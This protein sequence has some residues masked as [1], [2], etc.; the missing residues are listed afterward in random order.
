MNGWSWMRN[1]FVGFITTHARWSIA[2]IVAAI[3]LAATETQL[4]QSLEN[5]AFDV[6]TVATLP[7]KRTTPIIIVGIDD[8]S[9]SILGLGAFWPRRVHAQLIDALT[10]AGA[11]AIVFDV[12]FDRRSEVQDDAALAAAIHRAGNVV[13]GAG[14]PEV[15]ETTFSKQSHRREPL[16]MFLEAGATVGNLKIDV[17]GDSVVRRI[18]EA[19]DA[20]WRVALQVLKRHVPDLQADFLPAKNAYLRYLEPEQAPQYLPYIEALELAK[21]PG[22][23]NGA[24]MLVGAYS[25]RSEA[26]QTPLGDA[27]PYVEVHATAIEN[28]IRWQAIAPAHA[29]TRWLLTALLAAACVFSLARRGLRA[30]VAISLAWLVAIGALVVILWRFQQ[31][32]LPPAILLAIPLGVLLG[33]VVIVARPEKF[34]LGGEPREMTFLFTDLEGFTTLTEKRML[35]Q[36]EQL[37]NEYFELMAQAVSHHEG[38]LDKFIGDAVMAFWGAPVAHE[39]HPQRAVAC[40]CDMLDALDA[41]NV[42]LAE[43]G[44]PPLK[45]RIGI[46]TGVAV[47]GNLGC[48]SRFSYTAL[49]DAVNVASRLESAN[50]DYGT[51]ILM[52]E[53]TALGLPPGMPTR[54]IAETHQVKGRKEPLKLFTIDH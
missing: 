47:V 7:G 17:D 36:T 4:G 26:L 6:L 48:P 5:R 37:L 31:M 1:Y 51:S 52:S 2:L 20:L 15:E 9:R 46:H 33:R 21:Q 25:K 40:A 38:T 53:T 42:K 23:L 14:E 11:G 29:F 12:M 27:M 13:L 50:K 8:T 32:F 30:G 54:V 16:P 34:E 35:R 19:P 3:A 44:R 24:V 39:D 45:M 41:F 18:P 49:G 10:T 28:A 22:I 43:R